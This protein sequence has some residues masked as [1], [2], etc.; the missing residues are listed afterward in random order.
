MNSNLLNIKLATQS[1][2][3]L[4]SSPSSNAK[5]RLIFALSNSN[6]KNAKISSVDIIK[7][8]ANNCSIFASNIPISL[9]L[10]PKLYNKYIYILSHNK[11]IISSPKWQNI[12]N[13][14]LSA[15]LNLKNNNIPKLMSNIS[16]LDDLYN[17]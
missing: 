6:Y 10:I 14:T 15:V 17:E 11:Y 7:I 12:N 1:L 5:E 9:P 2:F 4:A 16:N 8:S 3:L 13:I